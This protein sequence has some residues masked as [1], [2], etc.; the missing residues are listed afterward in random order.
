MKVSPTSATSE[1]LS[2]VTPTIVPV[3]RRDDT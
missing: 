2:A 3:L 1:M